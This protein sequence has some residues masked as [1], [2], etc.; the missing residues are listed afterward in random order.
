MHLRQA[1]E[2]PGATRDRK[3]ITDADQPAVRRV[4]SMRPLEP[5]LGA[6]GARHV[7]SKAHR[8]D[9]GPAVFLVDGHRLKPAKND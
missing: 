5:G 6:I 3:L 7:R 2:R 1:R 8:N 4:R 9:N